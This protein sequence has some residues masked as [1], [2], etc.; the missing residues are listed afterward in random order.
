[1]DS[2]AVAELVADVAAAVGRRV[3][4]ASSDVYEVIVREIP[5][6]DEDK[7]LLGVLEPAAANHS[8]EHEP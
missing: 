7:P 8:R 6:L 2:P 4:A 3:T 5:Q 1:M